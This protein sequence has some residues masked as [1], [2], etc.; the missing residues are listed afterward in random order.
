MSRKMALGSALAEGR[1]LWNYIGTFTESDT[2]TGI[3]PPEV[4]SPLIIATIAHQAR[5][6]IVDGFD[7]GHTDARA[8][9][10]M[11][12]LLAWHNAHPEFFMNTPW[13]RAGVVLSLSSR[14]ALHR[15]LIPA[16]LGALL[17][18]GVPTA[19]LRDEDLTTG[20]LAEFHVVT[21][22]T[23]ACLG[24]S[25]AKALA[26]WVRGGG[27]LVAA[28]DAG[29]YDV[30]GRK[31]PYSVLYQA[32]GLEAAPSKETGV[33][34]GKVVSPGQAAF[35][36]TAV[37]LAQPHSF[38][39]AQDS[40]VE[41][42]PYTAKHSLTLHLVRHQAAAKQIALRVP[43]EFHPTTMTA[44]LRTPDSEQAQLLP[45]VATKDG[46]TL[47]LPAAPEYGVIEIPVR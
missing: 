4:I 40:G 25:S 7:D 41:V 34:R 11:A 46:L 24:E 6:W 10:A 31:L 14:N 38:L 43:N 12:K 37:R 22:E 5:P 20:K 13:A 30:L 8:R 27:I 42:V 32:L 21:V 47:S 35:S 17:S 28:L 36:Q 26:D 45:L 9:Q 23:A 3:K 18:A 2:Y 16:S 33:G 44:S 1:P 39:V 29:C 15:A 19:A